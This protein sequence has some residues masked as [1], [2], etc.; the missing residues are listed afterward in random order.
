MSVPS[1]DIADDAMMFDLAPVSLW[2]EDYSDVKALF[3]QWQAQ[4]VDDIET[5]LLANPERV[6]ECSQRIRILKVNR[7]T[8]SL[9]GARDL[10]SPDGQPRP[11]DARR[12]VQEPCLRTGAAVERAR[13]AFPATPSTTR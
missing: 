4:G 5:F 12:H 9:F 1:T 11:G 13:P 7:K 6:R 10:D 2:I 3:E 8:L